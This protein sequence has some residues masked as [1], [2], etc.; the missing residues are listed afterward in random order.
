MFFIRIFLPFFGKKATQFSCRFQ[1]IEPLLKGDIFDGRLLQ[2]ER[3]LASSNLE[4]EDSQYQ[5]IIHSR[6]LI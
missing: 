3:V 4:R 1:F 5:H 6:I 2:E